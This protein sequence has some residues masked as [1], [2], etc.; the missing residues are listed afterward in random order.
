M[1]AAE[2]DGCGL[3]VGKAAGWS[4]DEKTVAEDMGLWDAAEDGNAAGCCSRRGG[5]WMRWRTRRRL[6][7]ADNVGC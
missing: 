4:N 7:A 6:A 3:L 1:L 5:H 2:S